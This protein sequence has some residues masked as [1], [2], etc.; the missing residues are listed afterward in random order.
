[1]K[2][3]YEQNNGCNQAQFRNFKL[4]NIELK[5]LTIRLPAHQ[6]CA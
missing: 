6:Q 2:K 5:S 1:M 3:I 4:K